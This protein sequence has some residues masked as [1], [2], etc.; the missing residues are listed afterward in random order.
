MSCTSPQCYL[1]PFGGGRPRKSMEDYPAGV[2]PGLGRVVYLPCG[3]C[4]SCRTERRQELTLLQCCEASLY[5]D[6]W[7]VTLTYD[8]YKTI[9]LDGL[10]PY[11]LNKSHIQTFLESL[12]KGL[13][14]CDVR[15]RYFGCGEYG[16][17]YNRPHYH[18]SLFGCPP[19]V[20]GLEDDEHDKRLRFERLSNFGSIRAF[21]HPELDSNGNPFWYSPFIASRWPYGH[22]K[23]YRACRETFQ[24]VAGY[25]TKKLTGKPAKDR[26]K[27]EM[28]IPEFSFQSRPSIG[29]PWFD[30]FRNDI[31]GLQMIGEVVQLAGTSWKC[32]RIFDKWLCLVDHFDGP[33]MQEKIKLLRTAKMDPLPDRLDLKRKADYEIYREK[34]YSVLVKNQKKG[35]KS[36]T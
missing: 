5:D 13:L 7:F 12:R 22:H 2:Y 31:I 6:N 9:K 16:D 20:L 8:D 14:Y 24:Y 11:S 19:R 28:K 10:P 3:G 18:F 26:F 25:V 35:L 4:I 30:K 23:I 32:P 33:R 17:Q 29:W 27:A 36:D 15:P 34:Q 21:K 1:V